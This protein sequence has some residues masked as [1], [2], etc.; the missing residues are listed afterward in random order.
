MDTAEVK[1]TY[2]DVLTFWGGIVDTQK[3]LPFGTPDEVRDQVK[4]QI[5]ILA[6]G[7]GF[8]ACTVHNIQ[9]EVPPQNIM[10]MWE[11]LQ[12]YGRY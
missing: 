6:P 9:H 1:K 4:R 11:T 12:E 5:E 10:A 2:G 8:V 7:G 3:V